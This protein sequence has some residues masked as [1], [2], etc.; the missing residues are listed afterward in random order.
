M[1]GR[2]LD[3]GCDYRE[4]TS[5]IINLNFLKFKITTYKIEIL[6]YGNTYA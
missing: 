4:P 6:K 3:D 2:G 5:E 1:Y